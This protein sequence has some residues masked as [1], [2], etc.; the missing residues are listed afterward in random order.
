MSVHARHSGGDVRGSNGRFGGG[1]PLSSRRGFLD[2]VA[3]AATQITHKRR[4]RK[5]FRPPRRTPVRIGTPFVFILT[6]ASKHY[7]EELGS[8]PAKTRRR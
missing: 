6:N 5:P 8:F 3:V 7:G 4:R 2:E 1:G